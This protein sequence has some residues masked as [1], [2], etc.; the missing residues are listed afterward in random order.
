MVSN[1]KNEIFFSS[2]ALKQKNSRVSQSI[3]LV[4]GVY[5]MYVKSNSSVGLPAG[6]RGK[7]SALAPQPWYGR[8]WDNVLLE[9]GELGCSCTAVL[10]GSVPHSATRQSKAYAR[11]EAGRHI[12]CFKC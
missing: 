3:F 12:M 6:V 1:H 2:L 5:Q 7:L 9:P 8:V 4:L 10:S 11:S